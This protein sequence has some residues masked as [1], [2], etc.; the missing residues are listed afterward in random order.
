MVA[1][2]LYSLSMHSCTAVMSN[3]LPH[4]RV[5]A[6][7]YHEHHPGDRMTVLVADASEQD[8]EEPFDI[9]GPWELGLERQEVCRILT[10]FEGAHLAGALRGALVSH[11]LQVRREPIVFL[12]ADSQVFASLEEVGRLA[13]QHG[14]V[15]SPHLLDA[16]SRH[17]GFTGDRALLLA[18]AFNCGLLAV[19]PGGQGF[20]DWWSARL[21]RWTLLAPADGYYGAQRWLDLVPAMFGHHVL[22]DPG[23][24]VM[25][26]NAH[27]RSLSWRCGRCLARGRPLRMFHFGGGFDPHQPYLSG[28]GYAPGEALLSEHPPLAY[29]YRRYAEALLSSGWDRRPPL[30]AAIELEPGVALDATMRGIYRDALLTCEGSGAAEPPTPYAQGAAAFIEWLRSPSDLRR[31]ACTVSRYLQARWRQD[32]LAARFPD[33]PGQDGPRYLAWARSAEGAAAGI[34]PSIAEPATEAP[35]PVAVAAQG[36]NVVASDGGVAG[37]VGESLVHQMRHIGEG[38][39]EIRYPRAEAARAQVA[40]RLADAAI[41]DVT[42][43]CLPLHSV[44][45]FDYDLGVLFRP[46]RLIIVAVV[47]SVWSTHDLMR[48]GRIADEIWCWDTCTAAQMR[49]VCDVNAEALPFPVGNGRGERTDGEL[50]CW[51]DLGEPGHSDAVLRGVLNYLNAE[52]HTYRS[53]HVYVSDWDADPV[54][55]ETLLGL[56]D[57]HALLSVQRVANWQEALENADSL[58]SLGSGIGPVEAQALGAGIDLV[59]HGQASPRKVGDQATSFRAAAVERLTALRASRS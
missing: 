31:N 16:P 58:L 37:F 57:S 15:L 6:R 19:G 14:V 47:D 11:L 59:A 36:V 56:S 20:L 43:I 22:E 32:D 30:P 26:L 51:A 35:S 50:A 1:T 21:R 49:E 5:L 46:G 17:H 23:C 27:E 42:I 4:A 8:E 12:D 48:A 2:L 28:P 33:L 55:F 38:I 18:G 3:F 39:A 29:L 10:L 34:P 54:A 9:V 44:A 41:G 53:I 25:T 24:N 13:A 7:S 45:A 40:S 52:R